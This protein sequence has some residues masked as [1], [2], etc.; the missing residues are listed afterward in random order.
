MF[1][2]FISKR[3]TVIG[4]AVAIFI[5]A[6]G[7]TLLWQYQRAGEKDDQSGL[8]A[9]ALVLPELSPAVQAPEQC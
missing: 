5:L 1:P 7:A 2:A 3:P 6:A 9:G 4:A 8:A